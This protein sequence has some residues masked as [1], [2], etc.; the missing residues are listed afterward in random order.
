EKLAAANPNSQGYEM[1]V[2]AAK[3]WLRFALEDNA[4]TDEA[5]AISRDVVGNLHRMLQADPKNVQ[6]R[7]NLGVAQDMLGKNLLLAGDVAGALENA[8]ASVA[9]LEQ[10][11]AE[12]GSDEAKANAAAAHWRLGRA[13]AANGDHS[14]AI[15]NYREALALREPA[16]AAN[17]ANSRARDDVASISV[18][19]GSALA[20]IADFGG[21]EE[22]FRK[23]LPLAEEISAAAPSSA[24]LRAHLATAHGEA[25]RVFLAR[26][27]RDQAREH[28]AKSHALW[29]A[30]RE[31]GTL[32]PADTTKADDAARELAAL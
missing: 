32:I 14:A 25:G 28:L 8:H 1:S 18:D 16:I 29:S 22:A 5:I 30:L 27:D 15:K 13:C 23:A 26:G 31:N 7:R 2:L 19:L 3:H 17:A 12:T 4:R 10:V 6:V 24:R 9:V 11:V 20:S 21:A